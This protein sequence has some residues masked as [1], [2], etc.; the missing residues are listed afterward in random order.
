MSIKDV[1]LIK[2][3]NRNEV[4]ELISEWI[5][6]EDDIYLDINYKHKW[7]CKCENIIEGRTWKNI[8]YNKATDCGCIKHYK[9]EKRY[10]YEVEKTGEYEYI[11]SYRKGD[12]L[13][14]G[15]IVEGSPY[16]KI[17]HKYCGNL[18]DILAGSFINEKKRCSKCC[19]KYEKSFAY[20]I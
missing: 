7:R 15:K 20:H 16:I 8:K 6:L 13:P 4:N 9:M 1:K 14:N 5:L 10:K 19:H 11:R 3:M 18:Y 2:G 12:I 17:K